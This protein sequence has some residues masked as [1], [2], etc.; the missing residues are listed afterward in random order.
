MELSD[1]RKV[2]STI[3]MDFAKATW[4]QVIKMPDFEAKTKWIFSKDGLI[5]EQKAKTKEHKMKFRCIDQYGYKFN[6]N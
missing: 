4:D 1:R 2:K 5:L 3:T 6:K